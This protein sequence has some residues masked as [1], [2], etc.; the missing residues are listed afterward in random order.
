MQL[1]GQKLLPEDNGEENK[2]KPSIK[3]LLTYQ[4][5]FGRKYKN[6]FDVN[7]TQEEDKINIRFV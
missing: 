2:V 7:F 6:S 4:D 5:I 1:Y 3:I